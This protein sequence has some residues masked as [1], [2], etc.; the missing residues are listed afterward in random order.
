M[1]GEAFESA[2]KGRYQQSENTLGQDEVT[3]T[4]LSPASSLLRAAHSSC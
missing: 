3:S 1:F 4:D 2:L